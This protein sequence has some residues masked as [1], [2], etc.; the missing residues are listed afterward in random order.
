MKWIIPVM[1][2]L[3]AFLAQP[4]FAAQDATLDSDIAQLQMK[5]DVVNYRTAKDKQDEAFKALEKEA[6][7]VVQS[8][9]NTA[10]PL[11]WKAIILS[12]HA[13]ATGGLGA[14]GKVKEA[15]RL[16]VSAETINPQVLDG[17]I[18]TS[19]GSLYYQVPGWPI[20]FG[21]DEKAEEYLQKALSLN[22]NGIDA[23][24]FYGDFLLDQGRPKEAIE[25][26]QRAMAA[27]DRPNRSV[28]DA[29]RRQQARADLEKAE[30][31]LN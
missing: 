12:S 27:P 31:K 21:D 19:L 14:L 1:G 15:R 28:G 23:N 11:V 4:L 3:A 13:G 22:P 7:V 2:S 26:L 5:W 25:Y 18:Y 8:F 16:L 6:D 30:A 17:S 10:E 20:G 24:Y 9:P 29:G